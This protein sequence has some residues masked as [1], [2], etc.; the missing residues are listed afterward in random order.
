MM[1]ALVPVRPWKTKDPAVLSINVIKLK[2][3]SKAH[4]EVLVLVLVLVSGHA[5]MTSK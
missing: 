2:N 5:G 3:V 1:L 4:N